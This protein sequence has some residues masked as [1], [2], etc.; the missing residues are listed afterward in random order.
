MTVCRNNVSTDSAEK[1]CVFPVFSNGKNDV[2]I[3]FAQRGGSA[4]K[5]MTRKH[6]MYHA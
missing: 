4:R 1:F 2:Q 6:V 3:A 5:R